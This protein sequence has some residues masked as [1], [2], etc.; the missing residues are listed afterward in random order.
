MYN[1]G[2]VNKIIFLCNLLKSISGSLFIYICL[3]NSCSKL[4]TTLSFFLIYEIKLT[5]FFSFLL[6][7]YPLA[8][9]FYANDTSF[10][11]G[12]EHLPFQS[13]STEN[14]ELDYN[15]HNEPHS[16]QNALNRGP[17]FD[18]SASKNV[19][20]LVGKTAN[21]NCRIKNLGNKTVS[22]CVFLLFMQY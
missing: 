9:K 15:N 5:V 13:I 22:R 7:G 21:L 6:S 3:K 19:T 18:I 12:N 10:G 11:I 17:Y 2:F 14:F 16:V 20:A 1:V 8:S 4:S